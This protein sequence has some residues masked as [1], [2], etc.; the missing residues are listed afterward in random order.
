M[1][2]A[3][4]NPEARGAGGGAGS[5]REPDPQPKG[6]ECKSCGAIVPPEAVQC[7]ECGDDTEL[8][9][10]ASNDP[11]EVEQLDGVQGW[12]QNVLS[13]GESVVGVLVLAGL[14]VVFMMGI[15]T[16]VFWPWFM[17]ISIPTVLLLV[18]YGIGELI[19]LLMVLYG[20]L[21]RHLTLFGN[22]IL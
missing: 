6:S 13:E 16:K 18:V 2:E 5:P 14:F 12:V 9:R 7:P 10:R 1:R 11:F 19:M 4:E 15:L 3:A 17:I 22:L 20:L 8:K 21:M